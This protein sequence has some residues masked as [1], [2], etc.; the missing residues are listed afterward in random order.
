[1]DE[2][3]PYSG[4]YQD[5][6]AWAALNADNP[7]ATAWHE[8]GHALRDFGLFTAKEWDMLVKE[9]RRIGAEQLY[10]IKKR[11]DGRGLS[12][13][14]IDEEAV[15][16]MLGDRVTGKTFGAVDAI[17]N[18]AI[19]VLRKIRDALGVKG[20]RTVQDLFDDIE[21]GAIGRREGAS[22]GGPGMAAMPPNAPSWLSNPFDNVGDADAALSAGR[23]RFDLTGLLGRSASAATRLVSRHFFN[24]VVGTV[25][26]SVNAQ[27]ADLGWRKWASSYL[28]SYD[29]T[30]IP[31]FQE[32]AKSLG[33]QRHQAF[34]RAHEFYSEVTDYI[35]DPNRG[36][37]T[38]SAGVEKLAQKQIKLQ[39]EQGEDLINPHPNRKGG[40]VMRGLKGSVLVDPSDDRYMHRWWSTRKVRD[41][42]ERYG[43]DELIKL[44]AGAISASQRSIDNVVLTILSRAMVRNI[45]N[46]SA[47]LQEWVEALA[48]A[49]TAR[50]TQ[51]LKQG[52]VPDADIEAALARLRQSRNAPEG[53]LNSLHNRV[54]LDVHHSMF[55][56]PLDGSAP[57]EV[58]LNELL[59]RDAR[60]IFYRQ[61]RKIAGR[62]ALARVQIR[63]PDGSLIVNGLT[64]D[65]EI[66]ELLQHV[67][68]YA[69]A[70]GQHEQG[71][72]DVERL[73]FGI[74]R[75]LGVPMPDS[76]TNYAAWFRLIRSYMAMRLMGQVGIAQLGETGAAAGHLGLQSLFRQVPAYKHVL[77]AA[78]DLR[79]NHALLEE[80]ENMGIGV[81]RLHGIMLRNWDEIGD[82]PF[83]GPRS[84]WLDRVS[85]YARMGEQT[86]YEVSGMSFIQQRQEMWVAANMAN[87]I[88]NMAAKIK[89]GKKLGKGDVKRLAQLGIDEKMMQRIMLQFDHA[90]QVDGVW[91]GKKL[92]R[93]NVDRWTDGD[94]RAVFENALFRATRKIIQSQDEGSAAIWM[95][96]ELA[97]TF[98][99]FRGYAFTA[100]ANQTLYSFHMRDA[101]ALTSFATGMAWAAAIRAA[102]VSILASTRSD[103]DEFKEKHLDTW[104]L[105][106]AGFQRT[107]V[108]SILPMTIDSFLGLTGQEGMWNAR[109]SGQASN[110]IF[111]SPAISFLDSAS[112]GVGGAVN[113]ILEGRDMS[114][115]EIRAAVGILPFSNLFPITVGLSRM[116]QSRD[117][118]APPKEFIN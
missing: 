14:E 17:L 57:V 65:E 15:M 102:Q 112:K 107:G 24:D 27:S 23:G 80:L 54:D 59:E 68:D 55:L 117:E 72:I 105:A 116:V 4:Y 100:W 76:T 42:M 106:K 88:A 111:G 92:N 79:N 109:T 66:A 91:F 83:D 115:S 33:L 32:W 38:W 86:V 69:A 49:D 11:Y 82:N 62:V 28:S 5:G 114:Q 45:W 43:E 46:R 26:H 67:Q 19:K 12:A 74:D 101:A 104:E 89:A 70:R 63:H 108:S 21:S 81:E 56:K 44:L 85:D 53:D 64:S 34:Q 95:H 1:V 22:Q 71:K 13:D 9:A 7:L 47:G 75:I 118:R 61:T 36:S 110:A 10:N 58:F 98:F 39:K 18:K 51:L 50:L 94:A 93:L 41:A 2:M 60:K 90:D 78:G 29:K 3:G 99:Q 25:D 84:P 31:A 96:G 37:R 52:G 48:I 6:V 103:K 30:R 40:G 97:K 8:V 16:F 73:R 35:D 77:D 20:F 87:K 113:S